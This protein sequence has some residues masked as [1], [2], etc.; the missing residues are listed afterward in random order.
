MKRRREDRDDD[1]GRPMP[2]RRMFTDDD[3]A[4]RRLRK[5][6]MQLRE[7]LNEL[8]GRPEVYGQLP[9][10][11]QEKQRLQ[12]QLGKLDAQ[13]APFEQ[14]IRALEETIEHLNESIATVRR[15]NQECYGEV[16]RLRA[17]LR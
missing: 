6:N 2:L 4:V 17:S 13:A 11:R 10:L 5:E 3:D 15:E 8:K 7:E 12:L 16:R 9:G 14:Q 1:D